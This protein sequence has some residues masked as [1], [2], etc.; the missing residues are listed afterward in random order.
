[1]NNKER[2]S[3]LK[4]CKENTEICY[5]EEDKLTC[6]ESLIHEIK[7]PANEE[8]IYRRPYGLPHTQQEKICRQIKK[9]EG[10]DIL[11]LNMYL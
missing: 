2:Q 3:K 11:E 6:T 10:N 9:M 1:M 7:I 8:P 5:L 4:I